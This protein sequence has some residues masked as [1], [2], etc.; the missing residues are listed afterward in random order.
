MPLLVPSPLDPKMMHLVLPSERVS[1]HDVILPPTPPHRLQAALAGMLEEQLLDDPADLH[2]AVAPN[3]AVAMKTGSTF[4][5]MVC[6]KAWLKSVC[7]KVQAEGHTLIKIVPESAAAQA[8]GWNLA[9]F[10]FR[11]QSR[12]STQLKA[13]LRAVWQ[14]P[15]WRAARVAVLMIVLVQ[16]L[17]LNVW[18]WRDRSALD[19]KREQI[20]Q[21]L[22]QTF[23][24]TKVVIDA[25]M[26]MTKSLAAQRLAS[27]MLDGKGL[28]ALLAE[29]SNL[30]G[31]ISQINYAN[32]ELKIVQDAGQRSAP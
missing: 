18:A 32:G 27:G 23:P 11:V 1:V 20:N 5:V 29:K 31:A 26:Q 6:D 2:F 28:E 17:G 16:I 15:E 4:E 25:P 19:A 3:A 10:E 12:W 9:Q 22:T 21:I 8:A 24:E 30:G 7:D 13:I 14:A